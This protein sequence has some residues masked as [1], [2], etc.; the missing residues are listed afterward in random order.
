MTQEEAYQSPFSWRYGSP[1]MRQVWSEVGKHRLWRKM[2]AALARAQC[3][4]GLVTLEQVADLE[5]HVDEIDL[6]QAAA[7][8]AEIHHDLM[9][10]LKVFASQSEIGGGIIHLGATSMDIEDNADVLRIR[11]SMEF[12]MRRLE[13]TLS[14]LAGRLDEYVNLPVIGYTHLQPAEPTTLGYRLAFTAQELLE[15]WEEGKRLYLQLRGKGFK[16]AVGTGAAYVELIGEDHFEEFETL[17]SED[18]GLPFFPITHQTYP[19][20]QDYLVTS[21]LSALAGSLHKL[22]FDLRVLQSPQF[23]EISEPFSKNQVGSS[24]MPFKRNPINAEKMDSLARLAAQAPRTAWDNFAGSLLERTLDDSANRRTLLPESFLALDELLL[25]AQKILEGMQVNLHAVE[26]NFNRYAPFAAT[27]RVLLQLTRAGANRVDAHERLRQL[28][29]QAWQAV[30]TGME[31][32]LFDLIAEDNFIRQYIQP[33]DL[34]S[35]VSIHSHMGI[36]E[37]R[38]RQLAARIRT[39]IAEASRAETVTER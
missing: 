37:T 3:H 15:E 17:I 27:E 22:A 18:I 20:R 24:A 9:A 29:M 26:Q 32:P 1:E 38:T 2:W 13:S 33:A 30:S 6:Q 5:T 12:I 7:L 21:W 11:Q 35:L 14:S 39:T 4:F 28:S 23:G 36:A 10:E 34:A 19:R 25:T 8:E 16:G 31:N